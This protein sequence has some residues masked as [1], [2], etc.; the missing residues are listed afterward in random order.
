LQPKPSEKPKSPSD[1]VFK[2]DP[3][4]YVKEKVNL[5]VEIAKR[6][7][8]EAVKFVP[9]VAGGLGVLA[10]TIIAILASVLMGSGAVPSQEQLKAQAKKAKATAV[11]AKDKAAEA[12]A[13]GSEKAQVEIN[14][15]R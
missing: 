14:K 7:P 9:E 4:T 6:D 13:T 15:R 3:V 5:F 11:D 2:D 8:V 12:I 10:V 1:L